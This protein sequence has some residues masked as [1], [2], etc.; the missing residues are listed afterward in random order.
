MKIIYEFNMPDDK[1]EYDIAVHSQG[2]Y[3]AL[4][5]IREYVRSVEKYDVD[6]DN[7]EKSLNIIRDI[8]YESGFDFIE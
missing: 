2:M 4:F 1:Y 8:I 6:K 3:N 7:Q 5:E